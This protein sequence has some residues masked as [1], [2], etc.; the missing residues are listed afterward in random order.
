MNDE[1]KNQILEAIEKYGSQRAA[2]RALNVPESTLR[3]QLKKARSE[4]A[5]LAQPPVTE[6]VPTEQP[7]N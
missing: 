6:E 7:Q 3:C 5:E 4:M 1:L 2:A